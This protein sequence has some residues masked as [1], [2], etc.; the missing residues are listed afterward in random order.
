MAETDEPKTAAELFREADARFLSA[1]QRVMA[2]STEDPL[3]PRNPQRPERLEWDEFRRHVRELDNA[4]TARHI[5]KHHAIR[6]A[7]LAPP[8]PVVIAV[9]G[10]EE[11]ERSSSRS[12]ASVSENLERAAEFLR[13]RSQSVWSLA[14]L[15]D[16]VRAETEREVLRAREAALAHAASTR[17]DAELSLAA[18]GKPSPATIDA[19]AGI[20]DRHF[21]GQPLGH[22]LT[23][24]D[25]KH[26]DALEDLIKLWRRSP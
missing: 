1:V 7:M 4:A 19:M 9:V 13:T 25:A 17:V 6:E 22:G 5:A 3:Y 18:R 15:I 23:T 26:V 16:D 12:Y 14:E 8:A 21:P 24:A 10:E 2:A 20:L 11:P